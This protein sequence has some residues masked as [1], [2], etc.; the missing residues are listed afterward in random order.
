MASTPFLIVNGVEFPCPHV[1]F[2]YVWTQAVDSGRN[3]EGG[4]ASQLVG[5]QQVKFDQLEWI[6]LY[7]E[8]YQAIMSALSSFFV[9]VTFIDARNGQPITVD[10][11]TGDITAKPLFADPNTG[12]VTQ[13]E[14]VKVNLIDCGWEI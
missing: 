5:R 10:M 12:A 9:K 3:V 6:G 13:Y 7:P 4:I 8:Q 11:Y 1:G 2:Q 14:K